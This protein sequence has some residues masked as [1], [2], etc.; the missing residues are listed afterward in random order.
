MQRCKTCDGFIDLRDRPNVVAMVGRVC[1][2]CFAILGEQT[3]LENC[4]DGAS[5]IAIANGLQSEIE[6]R[7]E[8]LLKVCCEVVAERGMT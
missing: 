3:R 7:R 8:R 4:V 2:S 6:Q 5:M 1:D